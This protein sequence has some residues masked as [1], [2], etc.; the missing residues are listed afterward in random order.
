MNEAYDRA[1]KEFIHIADDVNSDEGAEAKYRIAQIYYQKKE[2]KVAENE[3]FDFIEQNTSQEYWKA[4]SFILLADVYHKQGDIFQA[5]HTL[6]SIIENYEPSGPQDDTI[7][8]TAKS[9]YNKL[10]EEEKYN[11]EQDTTQQKMEIQFNEE[12]K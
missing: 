3:V 1:M 2:Y 4:R 6:K 8:E 10:V 9:R 11:M 7:V 5:K 12:K